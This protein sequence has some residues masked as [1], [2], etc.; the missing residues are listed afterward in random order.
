MSEEGFADYEIADVL[1]YR[2]LAVFLLAFPLGLLIKG[3]RLVPLFWIAVIGVGLMSHLLIYAISQH[4]DWGLKLAAGLW[5]GTYV[6]IQVSILPYI[7]L[8]TPK[9]QHSEGISLS[10]LS[11]G[12]TYFLV[13]TLYAIASN[14]T[15]WVV[16]KNTMQFFATLTLIV[17]SFFLLRIRGKEHITRRIPF[18]EIRSG[19][20]WG[21]IFKATIPTVLIAI[22]AGFTIPVINL[23]FLHVHGVPSETFTA[24]GSATWLLVIVVML[25]MPTIRRRYGYRVAITRFQSLSVLALFGLAAT[26]WLLPWTGAVVLA[27]LCY[28]IRQPLMSA[29]SPMTSELVMYYVGERNQEIIASLNA[30]VWSGSWFVSTGIFSLLRQQGWSYSSIFMFTVVLYIVGITWYAYLIKVYERGR[31]SI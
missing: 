28:V 25:L 14:T 10:F 31:D 13:G 6:F 11:L 12:S 7:L 9:E 21:L 30:S 16:E 8:N 18:R 3:R 17:G 2:F 29:A 4:W 26:E 22:G 23:F 19:Y 1:S 20:D 27:A 15:T 5:G 24:L